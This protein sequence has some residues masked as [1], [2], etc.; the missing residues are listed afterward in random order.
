MRYITAYICAQQM[1]LLND[2]EIKVLQL[3]S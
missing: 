3:N 1:Y 2:Y